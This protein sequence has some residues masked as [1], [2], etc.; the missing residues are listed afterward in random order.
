LW[1]DVF[2][3]LDIAESRKKGKQRRKGYKLHER[4]FDLEA[5]KKID[6]IEPSKRIVDY[7]R[8]QALGP[9]GE[10]NRSLDF[11]R[12]WIRAGF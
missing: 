9:I 7:A 12:P 4:D 5:L 8:A 1:N 3:D 6:P 11:I 10:T 2:L